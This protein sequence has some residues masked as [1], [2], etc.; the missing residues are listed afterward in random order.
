MYI[1]I[2]AR[3]D[4]RQ[5]Q[6]TYTM[7]LA[8]TSP[9]A[10]LEAAFPPEMCEKQPTNNITRPGKWK[11]TYLWILLHRTALVDSQPDT[12]AVT[13]ARWRQEMGAIVEIFLKIYLTTQIAV[14]FK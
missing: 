2:N 14:P 4:V 6:H 10:A 3:P 8:S 12:S 5:R 11:Q 1:V 9:Q 13:S 7:L